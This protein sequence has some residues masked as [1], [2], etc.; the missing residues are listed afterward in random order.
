MKKTLVLGCVATMSLALVLYGKSAGQQNQSAA[1]STESVAAQKAIVTQY[2][3]TCHSDKAKAAGMDSARK[4]NF[5]TL[6][7]AHVEK[8]AETWELIVRKLR[9]GMMPP[10][11][12]KRPDPATYKGFITWLETEL[13]R[14]AVTYTPPPGL[15][16]L[17]RTEY[18]NVI[19]DMLDLDVD[20]GKYLPSDDSTHGFDNI[21]GALGVS[22][23]LVEAYVSAAQK[24]SRLAM[25]E[26]ATPS[27]TV[28]RTPEDTSQDYHIEG[29]PFGTRGGMLIKHVF[30][31]DGEYQIT[32]T[33]IFGDN[34]SPTGFGSV[35]CEKLEV[36]LDGE[37]IELL[38][39]QGGGRT[40]PANCGGRRV[41]AVQ[42]GQS[43]Q[44]LGRTSMKVRIST[45]AGLHDL[46]VTFLQTNFAPILDLDQ[47][48]MRDTVQ[49]GP[50]P[51]FTYFP[52]VGTVRIE[53]PYN[54]KQAEDSPSRRKI[55]ICR[56][57]TPADE[58]ACARKIISNLATH[59]FRRPANN[60]DV[61]SLMAFYQERRKDGNFEGG[62]ENA[63]AR[64]LTDPKFI[65]RI[66]AEP[67]NVKQGETYRISDI[68]LASRLSFFLWST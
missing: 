64:I 59:A 15:H 63:L 5:D 13:D 43:G 23:T 11:N 9:A 28:Y 31:S 7:I 25:G 29:L 57:T 45:K 4:I 2:C 66:E 51:G 30:P 22:S 65:Y 33:P 14:T 39:W 50:T 44:D 12:M 52:H 53:G 6:D 36:L 68:D 62:I 40:P 55:F 58:T 32:I 16:R 60:T 26:A 37:R 38:D 21:A 42:S 1:P 18:A 34:M 48:F 24:I 19:K 20:P 3:M 49:T 17:N 54:A 47:H 10:A 8:N 27:L 56:P 46:G 41:A 67:P 61:D 35:P